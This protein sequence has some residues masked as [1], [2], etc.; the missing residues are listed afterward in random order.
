M[1]LT[2]VG[3]GRRRSFSRSE[4]RRFGV[5]SGVCA[6][7][8]PTEVPTPSQIVRAA[9][10][11]DPGRPRLTWYDQDSGERVEL[12]ATS[13]NNWVD[14]TAHF[15]SSELG[16]G[17]GSRV[18]L[19]LPRHWLA[20]VSWLAVDLVGAQPVIGPDSTADVAVIGPDDLKDLPAN[21]EVVAISLRPMG[22]SFSEPLPPPVRDF[23]LEVRSQPDLY[24]ST[25][26]GDAA[27]G[28]RASVQAKAWGLTKA[29]RVA[30]AGPWE[31]EDELVDS[32]LTPLAA[33]GSVLWIRNPTVSGLVS[34]MDAEGVTLWVGHPPTGLVLPPAVRHLGW[35]SVS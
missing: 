7:T 4:D 16:I 35:P 8:Y 9:T 11:T 19:S 23:T 3:R 24:P 6:S 33:D 22:A 21:D 14:K 10:Q 29:D 25:G 2:L 31:S 28:H 27:V 5:A 18:S 1:I 30:A 12:S 20:A 17:P 32:L 13:L 34:L 15:L 26:S